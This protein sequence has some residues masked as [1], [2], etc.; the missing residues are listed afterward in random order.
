M[1]SFF[2]LVLA[3]TIIILLYPI[4]FLVGYARGRKTKVLTVINAMLRGEPE[5]ASGD[6]KA[7]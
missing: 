2:W 3:A 7:H 1:T 5:D 6:P 4:G